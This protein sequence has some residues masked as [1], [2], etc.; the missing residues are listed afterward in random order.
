MRNDGTT[1]PFWTT[2]KSTKNS[3]GDIVSYIIV[4][5]DIREVLNMQEKAEH[6]ANHD[7]LT[8]LLNRRGFEKAFEL[9]QKNSQNS[10]NNIAL[11]FIDLDHFKPINDNYGHDIGDLLLKFASKRILH[12]LRE[13]DILAR[14]GGDEFVVLLDELSSTQEATPI[15]KR[16][17]SAFEKDFEV[18]G[19]TL[20]TSPSIGVVFYPVDATSYDSLVKKAD[21]AMY[22]AKNKG[23][24]RFCF[25]T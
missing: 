5:T 2:I 12:C 4:Q 11:A 21:I 19:H 6:L 9:R 7:P 17:L 14:F 10:K 16:I 20:H 3:A 24:N 22:N 25:Y 18:K 8:G 23:K 13:V 1:F 15:L